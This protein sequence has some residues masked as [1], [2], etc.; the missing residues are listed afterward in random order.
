M[1]LLRYARGR[2]AAER[3]CEARLAAIGC[4]PSPR[5]EFGSF[6][7]TQTQFVCCETAWYRDFAGACGSACRVPTCYAVESEGDEVVIVL[8]D[9]DAAG[10]PLR[11]T[12]VN[13]TEL[14]ACL[15]W[16]ANFHAPLSGGSRV[17]GDRQLLAF[18]TRPDEL[19][20]FS[21]GRF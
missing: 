9:M 15:S 2:G 14:F 1:V 11:R 6:A 18:E 20:D 21:E 10:F 7:S 13:Q 12:Q 19:R 8:E 5:V 3:H 17:V 4:G 16:L